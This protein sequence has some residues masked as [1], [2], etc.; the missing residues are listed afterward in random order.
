MIYAISE[1]SAGF[2]HIWAPLCHDKTRLELLGHLSSEGSFLQVA[3]LLP[4]HPI[5]QHDAQF[6]LPVIIRPYSRD[7]SWVLGGGKIIVKENVR[8]EG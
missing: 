4:L 2:G 8:Q 6:P 1:S 5:P 7:K 3:P